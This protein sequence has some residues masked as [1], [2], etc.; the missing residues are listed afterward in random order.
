MKS[1]FPSHIV[2][3]RTD[4]IG[5]VI[6]TLPLAGY[7]KQL[8]PKTKIS[9]LGKSYTQPIIN[10]CEHIDAFINR[11]ELMQGD[12]QSHFKALQADAMVHVFPDKAIAF[13]AKRAH[14]PIRVGTSHRNHHWFNCNRLV[15]FT[16]K[17]SPL[18]EAQLN[19]QLLRGLGID[20]L[21]TLEEIS[22]L[23]GFSKIND[24][25][26]PWA[27]MLSKDR[28]KLILHSQSKGSA[29]EW[30]LDN[31]ARLIDLLPADRFQVFLTGTEEEGQMFR[32]ILCKGQAHVTDLS[33]KLSLDELIAFIAQCDGLIAASTGPLHIAAALGKHAVGIYPP[34]RPMH[35]GR[36]APLGKHAKVFVAEKSC[37]AC[38]KTKDCA[39]MRSIEPESILVY[40]EG[41][42]HANRSQ[43]IR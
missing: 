30:G 38:R 14:I 12:V 3:S 17:R 18:H 7:I 25:P 27:Q 23:F 10:A 16:R 21:P 36:W 37:D 41:M 34:I 13:A 8:Y 40:L 35:P 33:G 22:S 39:C 24:L 20:Y 19:F 15:N 32:T 2:I 42:V 31:F 9:F 5:D 4:S 26:Q 43:I 29:R 28:V 11:D 6:L 1:R